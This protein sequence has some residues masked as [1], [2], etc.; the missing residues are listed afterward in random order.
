[1]AYIPYGYKIVNGKAVADPE[2]SAQVRQLVR[3][4]LDGLSQNAAAREAGIICGDT[5]IKR[6]LVS[7]VYLGT[8]FYPPIL[9]KEEHELLLEELAARTHPGTTV[10]EKPYPAAHRFRLNLSED[11]F[12]PEMSEKEAIETLYQLLEPSEYGRKSASDEEKTWITT[13]LSLCTRMSDENKTTIT[14]AEQTKCSEKERKKLARAEYI[15]ELKERVGY[16]RNRLA[17][18]LGISDSTLYFI[19]YRK[20]TAS[21]K[22]MERIEAHFPRQGKP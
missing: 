17:K 7:T 16:S 19:E 21:N 5:T 12:R 10:S 4:Y 1:M 20:M 11:A 22:L 14:P 9:T 2:Q 18:E 13:C 15:E 8:D 3:F 6:I